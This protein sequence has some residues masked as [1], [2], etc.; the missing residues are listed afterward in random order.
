MSEE[1]EEARGSGA[2]NVLCV[3]RGRMFTR[4][5]AAYVRDE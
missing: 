4:L 3:L 1:S 5:W 2:A